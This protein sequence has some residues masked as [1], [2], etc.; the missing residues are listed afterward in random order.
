MQSAD[1]RISRPAS[2]HEVEY[3]AMRY[4]R[5][6]VHVHAPAKFGPYGGQFVPETLMPALAELEAAYLALAGRRRHSRPS[7]S[8]LLRTYVGRPTPLTHARRLTAHAGRRAD[9]PQAGRP[10][11]H[12]RAQDQQRARPGA[13]GP[14][15][16]QAAHH[17]RDRR[18]AARRGHGHRGRAAGAGVRRLHGHGGYRPPAAQRAAHAAAGRGGAPGGQRQPHAQGRHQR[19]DPRLGDQRAATPTTCSARR[20]ARIP[21]RPWCATSSR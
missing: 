15:H 12:R 4:H 3:V 21:T 18:R 20:S 1:E 16:G 7:S 10:G 19:G 17:R 9:L 11:P 5:S 13:A 14:A 2:W 6:V 8:D